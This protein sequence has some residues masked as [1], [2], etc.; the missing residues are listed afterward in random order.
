MFSF[1]DA[2]I[3]LKAGKKVWRKDI[4]QPYTPIYSLYKKDKEQYTLLL[5]EYKELPVKE[6]A[7]LNTE[8]LLAQNWEIWTEPEQEEK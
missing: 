3:H 8:E 1:E 5:R 2:L 7:Q 6:I 4:N